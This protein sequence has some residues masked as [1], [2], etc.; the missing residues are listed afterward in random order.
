MSHVRCER[1]EDTDKRTRWFKDGVEACL[2]NIK[3][4]EAELIGQEEPQ[5]AKWP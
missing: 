3:R 5:T 2:W 1:Q 4:E